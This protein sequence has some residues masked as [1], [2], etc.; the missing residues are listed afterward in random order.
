MA[1]YNPSP[2]R[3]EC[4]HSQILPRLHLHQTL[5]MEMVSD[6]LRH[7][8]E[9]VQT[10]DDARLDR[11]FGAACTRPKAAMAR[12][13]VYRMLDIQSSFVSDGIGI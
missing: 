9:Y 10:N 5:F 4:F 1:K 7:G 6:M 11:E 3:L 8:D 12:K 13:E 2:E